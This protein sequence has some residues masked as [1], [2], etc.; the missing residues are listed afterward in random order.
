MEN[1][2]L[3][4]QPEEVVEETQQPTEQEA[5]AQ[6]EKDWKAEALKYKA[7][8]ER[9][10]KQIEKQKINKPNNELS[11]DEIILLAKGCSDEDLTLLKKIQAGSKAMGQDVSI[12]DAMND[13]MFQA[14]KEKRDAAQKAEQAQLGA[15]GASG[16][17][18]DQKFVN[19]QTRDEHK[20]LW[21]EE[22]KKY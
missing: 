17:Y 1:E 20:K 5:A 15:S 18:I 14:F 2:E 4:V 22:I 12:T 8:A 16:N 9:K 10:E 13:P 19:G 21:E 6:G 3:E 7:I 11:R